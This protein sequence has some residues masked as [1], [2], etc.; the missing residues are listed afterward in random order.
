MCPLFTF[1][2][3]PLPCPHVSC[4]RVSCSSWCQITSL[5]PPAPCPATFRSSETWRGVRG[6]AREHNTLYLYLSRIPRMVYRI[7]K[8][9]GGKEEGVGVSS[10][11]TNISDGNFERQND[12]TRTRPGMNN[13]M[14]PSRLLRAT[15]GRLSKKIHLLIVLLKSL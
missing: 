8:R 13:R 15:D 10:D 1:S 14:I 5:A 12:V 11:D 2:T 4:S 6:N 3:S 7:T 9:H